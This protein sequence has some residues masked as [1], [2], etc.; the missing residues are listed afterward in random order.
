MGDDGLYLAGGFGQID[1]QRQL[2]FQQ[3]II[4]VAGGAVIGKLV[5]I[6]DGLQLIYM[7]YPDGFFPIFRSLVGDFSA[8]DVIDAA[9]NVGVV[10]GGD[11]VSFDVV[12]DFFDAGIIGN[13]RDVCFFQ[14][15][16]HCAKFQGGDVQALGGETGIVKRGYA[17]L[18]IGRM[19]VVQRISDFTAQRVAGGK[20]GLT[21]YVG[22]V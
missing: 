21:G 16:Q 14:P 7:L 19:A 2:A 4:S 6:R 13:F 15:A 1:L 17:A 18:D 12:R 3:A 22:V 11:A 5:R 10:G 8:F 20:H 9:G